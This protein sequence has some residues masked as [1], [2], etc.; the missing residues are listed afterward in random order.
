MESGGQLRR[1]SGRIG[2]ETL[3]KQASGSGKRR[4]EKSR[5]ED[6][7]ETESKIF[8]TVIKNETQ[9]SSLGDWKDGC[10]RNK[11]NY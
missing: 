9:I 6:N 5:D 3:P 2:V 10:H 1:L 8:A 11:P 4:R 7:V